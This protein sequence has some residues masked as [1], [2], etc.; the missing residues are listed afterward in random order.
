[1]GGKNKL[2]MSDL[3]A[4]FEAAGCRDVTTYIQSGNVIFRAPDRVAQRLPDL[5]SKGIRERFKLNVPVVIRSAGELALITSNNPF[6][7]VGA[8]PKTLHVLFLAGTPAA[9]DA[10]ALN[11]SRSPGDAF[12]VRGREIFLH[13]PNGV[14]RTK[15]TND[16][17]DRA[18]H[19]V[20][21]GRNWQTVLKLCELT[22][23]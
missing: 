13:L 7:T 4:V 12:V 8:D 5:I 15:L 6:L 21:T 10:A 9:E 23:E 11:P 22:K 3:V 14:A 20:T 17:F 18:L 2:P 19:A 1:V 16:Y